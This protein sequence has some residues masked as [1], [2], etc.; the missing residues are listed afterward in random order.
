MSELKLRSEA[1]TLGRE[2]GLSGSELSNF[3]TATLDEIKLEREHDERLKKLENERLEIE[4]LTKEKENEVEQKRIDAATEQKKLELEHQ[5]KLEQIKA[6]NAIKGE[7]LEVA[8]N[9]FGGVI[10]QI[11]L[12]SFNEEKDSFD[13][14][15]NRF[16]MMAKSQK[17]S[18]DQW[19]LCLMSLLSG[20][21]LE[22]VQ[23]MDPSEM[24]DYDKVKE[25]LMHRFRL[26]GE[27]FRFKFRKVRPE[28]NENPEQ[29][30]SR[31][32]NFLDRW[33]EL[34][35][36]D[37]TF[38]GLYDLVKR[39]Q[40]MNCCSK[41]MNAFIKEKECKNMTEV[42]KWAKTYVQAHGLHTFTYTNRQVYQNNSQKY[43][44]Q[45]NQS[46]KKHL[47]VFDGKKGNS[48]HKASGDKPSEIHRVSK[49]ISCFI[50]GGNH[51][52]RECPQKKKLP[53]SQGMIKHDDKN[54]VEKSL[55]EQPLRNEGTSAW[56]HF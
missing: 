32:G 13:A 2:M 1:A 16:E 14:Y 42:I 7:N 37:Q 51:L 55:G 45:K 12:P 15:I 26:T 46:G 11:Q 31:M 6:S 3:V 22:T 8:G 54:M 52:A 5:Y 47:S 44:E 50:C 56:I 53:V 20:T 9:P 28:K 40:F 23:R 24:V 25:T 43:N 33:I 49:R 39:E 41:E 35:H 18:K 36:I 19:A 48:Q 21:A 17:W 38:A 34:T 27:G 30:A 29:F 10:P 4:R